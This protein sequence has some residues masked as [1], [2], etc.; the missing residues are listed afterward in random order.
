[1]SITYT[2]VTGLDEARLVALI[3]P[4]LLAHEVVGV[5]L[6]WKTDSLGWVLSISVEKADAKL[7]GEGVTI[8][9]CAELSRELSNLFDAENVI[10]SAYR[11]EV[12]SPGLER[13][14]YTRNDF[15]RFSGWLAKVKLREP[16]DGAR[17]IQ[18]RISGLDDTDHVRF[19]TESGNIAVPFEGIAAARLVFD[20]SNPDM[21]GGAKAKSPKPRSSER[22]RRNRASKRKR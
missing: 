7:P 10:P 21:S 8:D 12:G 22:D 4:V 6:L 16:I 11:L 18:G 20:W 14:L 1:M 17:S 15:G 3:E 2:K 13:A 19:E 5:E 9:L